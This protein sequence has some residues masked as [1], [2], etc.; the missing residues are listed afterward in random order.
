MSSPDVSS[1]SLAVDVGA[2]YH[3]LAELHGEERSMQLDA[4]GA[5]RE[6]A[7]LQGEE[8]EA[9]DAEELCARPCIRITTA[10]APVPGR[11]RGGGARFA[12]LPVAC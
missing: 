3:Q 12:L 11:V 8:L 7:E 10:T 6:L 9:S 5:V 1:V 4:I 2:H